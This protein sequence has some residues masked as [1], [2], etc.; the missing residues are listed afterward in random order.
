MLKRPVL[1]YLVAGMA[2]LCSATQ[3]YAQGGKSAAAA[4]ELVQAMEAAK[5]DT[6]AVKLPTGEDQ[7]A[8]ALY[9]PGSQLLVVSARY[10]A[11]QL[12]EP[13]LAA[14]EY[15]E[16]YIELNGAGTPD[17]KVFISDLGANGLVDRKTNNMSDSW[18]QGTK[19]VTFD[20]DWGKQ[21]IQEADYRK[22]Y[23]AAD[24]DY[25]RILTALVGQTKK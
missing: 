22:S 11:P 3:S 23:T 20:G 25:A 9:I 18:E 10:S 13:R 1:F 7:F 15:R 16:V 14:K 17:S 19:R 5:L 6:I 12:L 2:L 4:K 21:K 24:E 8:A